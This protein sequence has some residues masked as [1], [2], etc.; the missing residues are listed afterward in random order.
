MAK[1]EGHWVDTSYRGRVKEFLNEKF[2]YL[3]DTIGD[4]KRQTAYVVATLVSGVA[5]YALT[6]MPELG[7]GTAIISAGISIAHDSTRSFEK[8]IAGRNQV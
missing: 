1:A 3:K 4:N 6:G 8:R 7:L 5:G 2:S